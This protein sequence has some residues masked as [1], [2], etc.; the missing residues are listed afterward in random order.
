[1]GKL[2]E[3]TN[4]DGISKVSWTP[5]KNTKFCNKGTKLYPEESWTQQVSLSMQDCSL[6]K[7]DLEK[8]RRITMYIFS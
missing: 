6:M 4:E 3:Q 7:N 1:M 5:G 8:S 2:E